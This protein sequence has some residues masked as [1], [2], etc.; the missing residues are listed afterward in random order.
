M[1]EALISLIKKKYGEGILMLESIDCNTFKNLEENY[2]FVQNLY[3]NALGYS[4]FCLGDQKEALKMYK[5]IEVNIDDEDEPI[6][7]FNVRLC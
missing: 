7:L 4:Y 3:Y 6:H 1:T 2:L 5:K